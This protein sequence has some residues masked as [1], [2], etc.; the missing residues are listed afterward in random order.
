MFKKKAFV[1][2]L[3]AFGLVACDPAATSTSSTPPE[4][5]PTSSPTESE[6]TGVT[7]TYQV[8][9]KTVHTETLAETGGVPT[10]YAYTPSE[11][12]FV[13]WYLT[14]T[15]SRIYD[16]KTALTEDTTLF[17]AVSIYQEDTRAFYLA[18]AGTSP[19]LSTS[20]WGDNPTD[21]HK[22]TKE[23]NKNVFTI[24]T[25]FYA[26]DQFQI[27][28]FKETE[29]DPYAW[30]WQYGVGYIINASELSDIV[31]GAGGIAASNRKSNIKILQDGNYTITLK[32]YPDHIDPEDTEHINNLD[33][34]T[35][36]R[37]GDP[38][39]EKPETTLAYYIKGS[40][41][42]NWQN[43]LNVTTRFA[44][45][46]D[47]TYK[48]IIYLDANEE[49]MF[50]T[51][52]TQADGSTADANIYINYT[53]LDTASQALFTKPENGN[54][55]IAK[56][57][58]EYTFLYTPGADNAAGSLAAT[59][60][61]TKT[62]PVYDYYLNGTMASSDG[63]SWTPSTVH[64]NDILKDTYKFTVSATDPRVYEL[65]GIAMV[66][67][68]EFAI[69]GFIAGSTTV[70]DG[71]SNKT[72][73]YNFTYSD[74]TNSADVW[75]AANPTG[76]NYNFKCKVAGTYDLSYNVYSHIITIKAAA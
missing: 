12:E 57:A 5:T 26:N 73:D 24:T 13:G 61:K 9:G 70:G 45:Q 21:A 16:F 23:A 39:E 68:A 66:A 72:A 18:G 62:L 20:S 8:D 46:Q 56:E 27:T 69:A 28:S 33:N 52:A 51:I 7:I 30:D 58:G 74:T 6:E 25:D 63:L 32:T 31:E 11:G 19:V 4:P 2:L 53:N 48:L 29:T 44:D 43:Q 1:V 49:F 22:L 76:G 59:V 71:W 10:N 60:D 42:T 41:I 47:G 36:K 65:K 35:I 40:K 64:D 54:N 14:P 75:E 55:I 67:N 15:F 3:A 37:N 17:G 34:I 50:H 38:V